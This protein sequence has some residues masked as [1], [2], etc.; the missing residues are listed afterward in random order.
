MDR[1]E[2]RGLNTAPIGEELA[3]DAKVLRVKG[4]GSHNAHP[5][6]VFSCLI[7]LL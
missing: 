6:L 2:V 7:F 3:M 4:V 5:K 1:N